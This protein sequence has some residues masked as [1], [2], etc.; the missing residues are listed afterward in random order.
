[1]LKVCNVIE[2]GRFGGPQSRIVRVA[3]NLKDL[4]VETYVLY[5]SFES[6]KLARRLNE[7]GIKSKPIRMCRLTKEVHGLFRYFINFPLE[8]VLMYRYFCQEKFDLIHVNGPYQVKGALAAKVAGIPVL[9]HINDTSE[10]WPV[11]LAFK[12]LMW[13]LAKGFISAGQ[14]VR[15]IYLTGAGI[16]EKPVYIIQAP[17]DISIFDPDKIS[18]DALVGRAEGFKVITVANINPIKGIESFID[19]AALLNKKFKKVTFFV[20]GEF[21]ESQRGYSRM[22]M[23]RCARLGIKNLVFTG[24]L[25][26]IPSVIRSADVYVCTSLKE[27][28]PTSVWEAMSMAKP[29]VSTDVG[30]VKL[31]V[32]D[33]E[34]G[35]VVPVGDAEALAE[36]VEKLLNNES[37]LREFGQNARRVVKESLDLVQCARLHKKA[38]IEIISS[39]KL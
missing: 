12:S 24:S 30:D 29:V 20:V 22:L 35:Y 19:M 11:K 15:E 25:D 3:V 36:R 7:E 18:P 8:I 16:D 5:P 10:V 32:R 21:L 17:V 38:Y 31:F 39:N 28:S 1:M 34:S 9:W 33:G 26:N 4:G 23:D 37:M 2:E 14:R 13:R 27:A 6:E